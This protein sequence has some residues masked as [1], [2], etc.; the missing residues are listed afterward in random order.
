MIC[1]PKNDITLDALVGRLKTF[2]LDKFDNYVPSSDNIE[3]AFQDK[4]SLKKKAA[5]SKS[6]KYDSEDEDGSNDDL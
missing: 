3:Y 1:D 4:L 6:K 5:K 2:E